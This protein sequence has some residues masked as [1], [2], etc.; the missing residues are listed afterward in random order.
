MLSEQQQR[1]GHRG[2]GDLDPFAGHPLA[3]EPG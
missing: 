3:P 1:S 2:V